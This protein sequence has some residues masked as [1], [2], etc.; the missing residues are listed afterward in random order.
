MSTQ[1]RT[2]HL[3]ASRLCGLVLLLRLG[4]N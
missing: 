1:Q 4:R 3:L 2:L